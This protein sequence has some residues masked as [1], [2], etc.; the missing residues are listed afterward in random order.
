MQIGHVNDAVAL[1][2]EWEGR[3]VISAPLPG[4]WGRV[5]PRDKQ[6]C[7]NKSLL[8]SLENLACCN[9]MPTGKLVSSSKLVIQCSPWLENGKWL[10]RDLD[11]CVCSES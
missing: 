4:E 2:C 7:L 11:P 8:F 1:N 6:R 5:V 3:G 10:G 9:Q